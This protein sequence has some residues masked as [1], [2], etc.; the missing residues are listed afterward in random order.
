[1]N[2]LTIA[3]GATV[4]LATTFTFN[5]AGNLTANGNLLVSGG[6]P[7]IQLSGT[8]K[9]L[10]GQVANAAITGTIALAG[11]TTASGNVTISGGTAT[12]DIGIFAMQ[13]GGNFSTGSGGRLIMTTAGGQLNITGSG[14]FGGG[15]ETG[16]LTA[17]TITIGGAFSQTGPATAFAPSGSHTTGF[18]GGAVTHTV[19]FQT[20]GAGAA[21]SHFASLDM[22]GAGTVSLATDVTV[23]GLLTATSGTPTLGTNG[24]THRLTAVSV[25]VTGLTVNQATLAIGGGTIVA[26][27]GVQF[28]NSPTTVAQLTVNNSGAA[29]AFNFTNLSFATTPGRSQRLLHGCD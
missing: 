4:T 23:D 8:G 18:T 7:S 3:A 6:T 24:T 25:S 5:V 2:D 13:V 15:S 26:F 9:T 11:T 12:L 10:S 20:P 1:M 21:G 14:A 17:G 29:T 19:S 22:S 27:S 16:V 28:T